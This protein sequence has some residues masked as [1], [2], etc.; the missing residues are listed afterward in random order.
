[1]RIVFAL[2]SRI[3]PFLHGGHA[4]NAPPWR[5]I[6]EHAFGNRM[7]K[8]WIVSLLLFI[9]ACGSAGVEV[10]ADIYMFVDKEGGIHF[11]NVPTSPE[12]VLFIK[13]KPEGERPAQA[14][15][16]IDEDQYDPIIQ[17]AS[18][19]Y[20]LPFSLLK[21]VIKVESAFNPHAV[22]RKGAVGLM[23]IMPENNQRL[24]IRNPY[25]PWENIMG[26][27]RYLKELLGKFDGDLSLA[28]A[29]YNAGPKTVDRYHQTIPPY[30][31]TENYVKKVMSC[32]Y[33][34]KD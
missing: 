19:K 3:K 8:S 11:T 22:S 21:A 25:D 29:A 15:F 24:K 10:S 31:E 12:Y 16:H 6:V 26:G 27:S 20:D 2:N 7:K 34:L 17:E 28:L 14:E 13:E 4:G 1:M 33:A 23:Q 32:Y 5:E 18:R 9:L 30:E